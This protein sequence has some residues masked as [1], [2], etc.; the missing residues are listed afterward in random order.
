MKSRLKKQA[1]SVRAL[2]FAGLFLL[3]PIFAM[4]DCLPDA[5]GFLLFAIALSGLRDLS[6]EILASRKLFLNL[7]VLSVLREI[8]TL[9]IHTAGKTEN[10]FEVPTLLLLL[11]FVCALLQVLFLIPAFRHLFRGL[12]DLG[13][14]Y[15]GDALWQV[16]RG[17]TLTE[18]ASRQTTILV[19][20][21]SVFT[22]LPEF[23]ALGLRAGEGVGEGIYGFINVY[24]AFSGVFLV[25]VWILWLLLWIRFCNAAKREKAFADALCDARIRDEL[26]HPGRAERRALYRT[27]LFC[28]FSA[29][30]FLP[31]R[32]GDLSLFPGVLC[33]IFAWIAFERLGAK[34]RWPLCLSL[35]FVSLARIVLHFVYLVDHIPKDAIY[36]PKAYAFYFAVRMTH[37]AEFLLAILL[38]TLLYGRIVSLVKQRVSILYEK[39]EDAED[40]SR[41]ATDKLQKALL[42]KLRAGWILFLVAS[43]F[44]VAD[45]LLRPGF[46]Y[47][48]ILAATLGAVGLLVFWIPSFKEATDDFVTLQT[49]KTV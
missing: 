22:T 27:L 45:L 3:T 9:L 36:E 33:A 37:I 13:E 31:I 2:L 28:G 49:E 14:R 8:L 19:L 46:A 40:A 29:L 35:I 18:R 16:K 15:G 48:W 32:L 25:I 43:A 10:A 5:F 12:S 7:F 30:V 38:V 23:G 26:E 11:S 44:C 4:I 21:H 24:R 41:H 34:N 6:D 42:A 20:F 17:R 47:L 1:I 39:G